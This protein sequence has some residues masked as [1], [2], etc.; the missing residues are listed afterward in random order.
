M[1]FPPKLLNDGEEIVLDLRPHWLFM[2]LS[3]GVFIAMIIV[4]LL[5]LGWNPSASWLDTGSAGVAGVGFLICLGWF[6]LTY[7]RWTNTHFVLTTDRIINREGI[8]A[9]RGVDIPLERVNTVFFNQGPLER[10][11]GAGDL[12]IESASETGAN[13]FRNVR[14]PSIVQKEIYTQIEANENRKF[15]RMGEAGRSGSRAPADPTTP[16][17][18]TIPEQID[19]L[20]ELHQRGVLSDAEFARK[21]AELLDR[22]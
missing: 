6:G 13:E 12:K 1:A 15:E 3:T 9:K 16:Q 17:A 2:A 7:A 19:Q 10:L 11:V 4:G 18:H 20:A 22:M 14:R 5:L 8:I 21:K